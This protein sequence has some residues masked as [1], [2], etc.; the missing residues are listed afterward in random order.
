MLPF[1]HI[2]GMTVIMNLG[3]RQ[4]ATVVT[5]PRFDL[6]QFLEL[7][8][9]HGVTRAFVVPPIALAL[10]KHPA[11]DERDL[12][13]LNLIMSGAAPLGPELSDQVANRIG[14]TTLQGY[15]LTETS[16]VTH[17][18]P[19]DSPKAGSIGP[20]VPNTE[21]RIVDPESGEDVGEGERGELWIRGPQVMKGYL[22]NPEATA[23]TVDDEGW[24]HTGDI[25]V[26]DDDDGYFEIVDRLKELIKYKGFQ[27]ARRRA[28]GAPDHPSRGPG[29]G[30]DR[31]RRRG[32]RRAAEGVHRAGRRARPRGPEGLGL[33]AGGAAEAGPPGRGDRG[34]PE[35]AL[36]QDPP[37]GPGRARARSRRELMEAATGAVMVPG[38]RHVP[39]NHCGSTA[40]RNLLAFHGLELSEEMAF[41]LGAG[42]CF[43]YVVIDG[44]SPSRFTNGRVSRLEEKF[45]E[46]T[47]APL[48]L[49]TF[50]D[51]DESW[52]AARELVDSGRPA[53]LLSDL[54][55][56]DHY[57]KSAHFP[58]HAVVL[59]GYDDEVAYLSDTAFEELKTTRLENLAT[60]RHE[61]LP[62]FPLDGHMFSLADGAELTD[63]RES[64]PRAIA[65]G[66]K[67]MLEPSMG[68]W[69]GLP[70]L[71]RFAAEVGEWPEAT[72]DWRWCA[73]FNYQVIERRGTGGGNFRAMYSRFLE[74]AGYP[75]AELAATASERWT[76]LADALR[77]ASEPEEP[78]PALWSRVAEAARPV[79]EAEEA[80][81]TALR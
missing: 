49:Q 4:G 58:G 3:L 67:Q 34:D 53:I 23:G 6:G 24:L 18:V 12:S 36:G 46:L 68:E 56:L 75:E 5:M 60:A 62:I 76:A 81:W 7:I 80:L 10:A 74:E 61:S 73:R 38:Y 25:A 66:A 77:E 21:C 26:R 70:A 35:V 30:G 55:H 50:E 57:G 52:R 79:L 27:V 59:A 33:R 40:L 1:F 17:C 71:R 78:E 41:G 43:Y 29:R 69:E 42:A 9:Q 65:R 47:G 15:G 14:C 13:S 8:E 64:V 48:E 39:G 44:Q 72:E 45:L 63:L 32:G 19:E 11:V 2:Y 31:G 20:P 28:R 37:P 51:G 54:Y 16:P 22:N